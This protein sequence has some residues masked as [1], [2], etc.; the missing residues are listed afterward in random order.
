MRNSVPKSPR[1]RVS[2]NPNQR[3]PLTQHF[4]ELR[5][6]LL[7]S[8]VALA[9]G[10]SVCTTMAQTIFD[11]LLRP[12]Y[13]V[14]QAGVRSVQIIY[15][16]PFEVLTSFVKIALL[17]GLVLVL[18]YIMAQIWGFFAPGLKGKERRWFIPF[19]VL[20]TLFFFAGVG[21]AYY[22]MIPISYEF[23]L[24]YA[25]PNIVAQFK[26]SELLS[27]TLTMLFMFGLLFELPLLV[28]LLVALRLLRTVQIVQQWRV[29]ILGIFVAAAILTPADLVSMLLMAL[30][31]C[32]LMLMSC[33]LGWIIERVW[34][35]PDDQQQALPSTD[36]DVAIKN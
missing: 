30:P 24:G 33:L 23:L 28:A 11:R 25:P 13:Q 27:F 31:L 10:F 7:R 9:I 19:V 21:F 22:V 35:K 18:P 16:N 6:R 32:F 36:L 14:Q 3:L 34:L 5:Q 15:T 2:A 17:A 4:L 29:I 26:T 20:T 1:R 12:L 8:L